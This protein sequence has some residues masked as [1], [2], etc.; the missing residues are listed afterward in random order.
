MLLRKHFNLAASSSAI[1]LVGWTWSAFGALTLFISALGIIHNII[2]SF[3]HH[4]PLSKP[5]FY[6]W[7]TSLFLIISSAI[8]IVSAQALLRKKSWALYCLMLIIACYLGD[9]LYGV[10]F[11]GNFPSF[12]QAGKSNFP[13][14]I[15]TFSTI[16]AIF[17][18][19]V[20]FSFFLISFI[21]LLLKRTR[22][23]FKT[24]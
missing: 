19:I 20:W 16:F 17:V 12:H 5:D 3:P 10:I 8:I 14:S 11:Q 21:L 9:M 6:T 7:I 24:D 2:S 23:A 4:F 22:N 18:E 1:Q 13:N 15:E